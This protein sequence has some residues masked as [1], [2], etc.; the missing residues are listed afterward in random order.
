[1]EAPY[2]RVR[3]VP[4]TTVLRA[5]TAAAGLARRTT[6]FFSGS[7]L[8]LREAALLKDRLDRLATF[9]PDDYRSQ[10]ADVQQIGQPLAAALAAGSFYA[11]EDRR[12]WTDVF[13]LVAAQPPMAGYMWQQG[14]ALR[15]L[16]ATMLLYAAVLGAWATGDAA[17]IKELLLL[18]L[19]HSYLDTAQNLQQLPSCPAVVAL[20]PPEVIDINALGL[21]PGAYHASNK[22]VEVIMPV[23]AEQYPVAPDF[24]A[25]F[26]EAEYLMALLQHN[27]HEATGFPGHERWGRTTFH[28]GLIGIPGAVVGP[29]PEPV[30]ARFENQPGGLDI[31]S[32]T[33]IFQGDEDDVR[34]AQAAIAEYLKESAWR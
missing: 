9:S 19:R 11:P 12:L 17:M 30:A 18:P 2:L 26:E 5:A 7:R 6:A 4:R 29:Q 34:N 15:R 3:V 16:P 14:Q 1:M 27:W 13:R 32:F 23:L 25:A 33:G 28:S 31:H 8:L 22:I 10:L 21:G 20:A 24:A